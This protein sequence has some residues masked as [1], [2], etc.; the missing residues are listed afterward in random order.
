MNS[1][2]YQLLLNEGHLFQGCFKSSLVALRRDRSADRG[3]YYAA[4]FHFAIGLERLLKVLV[5]LD[6]WKRE[7][8]FPDTQ[9][10]RQH[11]GRSG[12]DIE[13]LYLTVRD[14]FVR[15]GVSCPGFDPDD[16]D[17]RLLGY[18]SDFAKVSR[19][20]NLDTL[21]GESRSEDP[22][23]RWD[24]LLHE[25][26]ERDLPEMQRIHD[27]DQLDAMAETIEGNVVHMPC[28]SMGGEPQSFRGM[29]QDHG[30]IARALPAMCL[31]LLKLLI[32]L[33]E[34]L[35]EIRV[36]IHADDDH[37][38]SATVPFMEEFLDFVCRD[39]TIVDEAP[40]DWP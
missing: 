13:K 11:G 14:L 37:S 27:E 23:A 30:M 7:R 31:R 12:H 34:L 19:Y 33:K 20:F 38:Q 5:L 17:T 36:G 15:Y 25:V 24:A 1:P 39:K 40:E 18:L 8:R 35:I 32:P 21:V 29:V 28:E 16:L 6:H 2:T 4:S 3:R 9:E 10:L 26:Y 22:L